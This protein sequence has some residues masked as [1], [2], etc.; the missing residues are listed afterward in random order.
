MKDKIN[1]SISNDIYNIIES[2]AIKFEIFK[3]NGNNINKNRFISLLLIGY[4]ET[5]IY[6]YYSFKNK[7]NNILSKDIKDNDIIENL[8]NKIID[9]I[10]ISPLNKKKGQTSI[11]ISIKPTKD[12]EL[13]LNALEEEFCNYTKSEY[14]RS[15]ITSYCKYPIYKR[16]QIIFKDNYKKITEAIKDN[17]SVSFISSGDNKTHKVL[18]YKLIH[19]NEEMYN[20]LIC[21]EEIKNNIYVRSHRLNRINNLNYSRYNITINDDLK[22]YLNKTITYDPKFAI[23]SKMNAVVKLT[24]DGKQKLLKYIY[25]GRPSKGKIENKDGDCYYMFEGSYYQLY[26]YLIK[27][28][29]DAL[30]IEPEELKTELLKFYKEA[31]GVYK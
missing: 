2:D 18:P 6:E 5:F 23:N 24:E 11:N 29:K 12:N 19:S 15:I 7:I 30:V 28:G 4:Y 26:L 21:L 17:K 3:K 8:S 9:T 22:Y 31:Y 16:E 27:F 20:Y 1:V 14:L 13:A 25:Q 10:I